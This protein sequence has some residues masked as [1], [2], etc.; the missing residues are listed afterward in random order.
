MT[1]I[2]D[3]T[4]EELEQNFQHYLD[5]GII[6]L[7]YE[8]GRKPCPRPGDIKG[9]F[10]HLCRVTGNEKQVRGVRVCVVQRRK[11]RQ[12]EREKERER[13]RDYKP[14]FSA[15]C[16]LLCAC[17]CVL[18]GRWRRAVPRLCGG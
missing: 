18:A 14:T 9:E 13:E 10:Y 16:L 2:T 1:N 4:R 3:K 12:R 5:M 17:C 6:K 8:K 7:D 15:V 11:E